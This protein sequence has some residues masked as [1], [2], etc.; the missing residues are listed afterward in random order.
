VQLTTLSCI[1]LTSVDVQRKISAIKGGRSC[2]SSSPGVLHHVYVWVDRLSV[3]VSPVSLAESRNH[4][5]IY[6]GLLSSKCF[7]HFYHNSS[8]V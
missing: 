4:G 3:G 7:A 2:R 8:A 6:I 1:D 5:E